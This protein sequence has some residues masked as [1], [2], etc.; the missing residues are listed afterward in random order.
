MIGGAIRAR[1]ELDTAPTY[2]IDQSI[3]QS[4]NQSIQ[5]QRT[6]E[7]LYNYFLNSLSSLK[8]LNYQYIHL[9]VWTV[10]TIYNYFARKL[11]EFYFTEASWAQFGRGN[12]RKSN[13]L[14]FPN[15]YRLLKWKS[16][17]FLWSAFKNPQ[18]CWWKILSADDVRGVVMFQNCPL[19]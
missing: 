19:E 11:R 12:P 9:I 14:S 6:I 13:I 2:K 7:D 15:K 18:F 8:V 16:D 10:L 3:D 5:L 17:S 4:I 1:V